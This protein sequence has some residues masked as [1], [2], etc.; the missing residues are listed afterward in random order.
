MDINLKPPPYQRKTGRPAKKRKRSYD[1]PE[2]VVK[3]R[4]CGKCGSTAGHNKRTCAGGDVGKNPTGF[5]PS[6]EY[7]AANCTFT[8]RDHP[9]S[10]SARG[11]AKVNKSRGTSSFVGESTGPKNFGRAPAEPST[12]GSTQDVLNFSQNFTGIG[13]VSQHIPVTKG[14]KSKAKKK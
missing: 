8:S 13:S 5:M 11:K 6:T 14:K 9:E 1:E 10:S 2:T 4:K 12:H 7:D 3:K